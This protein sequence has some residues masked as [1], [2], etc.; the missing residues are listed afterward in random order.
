MKKRDFLKSLAWGAAGLSTRGL[1]LGAEAPPKATPRRLPPKNWVWITTEA[2]HTKD[3]WRAILSD[4]RSSGID[5]IVPE[6][7]DGRNAYWDST[8]LP[9]KE[10]RLGMFLDVGRQVGL[11][12]HAWMWTM[13]C[14]V[15]EILKK[16]P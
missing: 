14:M 4:M 16:H 15:E 8:R 13:P 5:A 1:A 10:D 12:V 7:Y 2:K 9:V 3:E 11:E 6:V